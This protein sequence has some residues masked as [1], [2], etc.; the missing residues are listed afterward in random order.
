MK[1]ISAINYGHRVVIRCVVDDSGPRWLHADGEAHT[2]VTSI[3]WEGNP[4]P[5][6]L[7]AGTECHACL[8]AWTFHEFIFTG[9]ELLDA[10]TGEPKTDDQLLEEVKARAALLMSGPGKRIP[11]LEGVEVT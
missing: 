8:D 11:Q 7:E 10:K 9:S 3:D 6:G 5:D 2:R 1:I 4:A